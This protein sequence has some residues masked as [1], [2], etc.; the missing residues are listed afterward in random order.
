MVQICAQQQP[1]FLAK[2]APRALTR[3]AAHQAHARLAQRPAARPLAAARQGRR[4][5]RLQPAAAARTMAKVDGFKVAIFS[6]QPFVEDFM[7]E[8]LEAAFPADSLK[9]GRS[10]AVGAWATV[11][12]IARRRRAAA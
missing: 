6:A 12:H 1:A 4:R 3:P 9:V 5:R 2:L 11:P 8:P 7:R 10:Q